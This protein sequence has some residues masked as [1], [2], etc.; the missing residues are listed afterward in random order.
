VLLKNLQEKYRGALYWKPGNNIGYKRSFLQLLQEC[1]PADYYAFADQDDVWNER[2]IIRAVT[3]LSKDREEH[4]ALYASSLYLVDENLQNRTL[5]IVDK[6]RRS[7]EGN[8]LRGT[9]AGCTFV[10]NR[11]LAELAKRIP[12]QHLPGQSVPSHDLWVSTCAYALGNVRIDDESFILHR[13]HEN[14]WGA[15]SMGIR[16]RIRIEYHVFTQRNVASSMAKII[17]K[18]YYKRIDES[19][20]RFLLAVGEN[21]KSIKNKWRLICYPGFRADNMLMN[22]ETYFKI[23]IGRY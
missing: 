9:M 14:S 4:P 12:V 1:E 7:L 3:M 11:E 21:T 20:R 8:F 2:K 5:K 23:L 19:K 16:K 18:E 17:L 15:D 10:F 22:A 13:R 6:S